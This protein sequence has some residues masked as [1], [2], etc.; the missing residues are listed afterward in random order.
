MPVPWTLYRLAQLLLQKERFCQNNI[1][2]ILGELLTACCCLG[3]K[4]ILPDRRGTDRALRRE[5]AYLVE[6]LAAEDDEP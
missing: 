1:P 2:T 4:D 6:E 5:I 3:E